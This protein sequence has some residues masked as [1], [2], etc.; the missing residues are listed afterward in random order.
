MSHISAL[1]HHERLKH[2]VTFNI[3]YI[4]SYLRLFN[5]NISIYDYIITES[6]EFSEP[7][8]AALLTFSCPT[9]DLCVFKNLY[10]MFTGGKLARQSTWV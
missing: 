3:L 8:A 6:W 1:Q 2:P 5:V 9:V 4:A 10:V 7:R